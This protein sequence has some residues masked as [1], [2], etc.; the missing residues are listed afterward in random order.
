MAKARSWRGA[1]DGEVALV[2]QDKGQAIKAVGG[3]GV[4][5]T[6]A[7][8]VDCEGA[9]VQAVGAVE[10]ALV[11]QDVGEVVKALGRGG[12]VG[13]QASLVDLQGP[14]VQPSGGH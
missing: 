1:S 2:A 13:S 6:Q 5:G 14:L 10:V 11:G 9:L 8:L 3:G 12:V 7:G 4:V